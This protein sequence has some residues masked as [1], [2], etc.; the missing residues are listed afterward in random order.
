MPDVVHDPFA[1]TDPR[2]ETFSVVSDEE[3]FSQPDLTSRSVKDFL[4]SLRSRIPQPK[5]TA[6]SEPTP[7]AP[8]NIRGN[9]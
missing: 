3:V 9:P 8:I 2:W 1:N 6:P 4:R 7:G 5:P